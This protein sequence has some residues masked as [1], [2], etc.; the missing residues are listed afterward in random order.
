MALQ[1][2]FKA[3]ADKSITVT[4]AEANGA[5]AATYQAK[6]GGQPKSCDV[7]HQLE[8]ADA[9]DDVHGHGGKT[10]NITSNP[11]GQCYWL[12]WRSW[13]AVYGQLQGAC[14][15]FVTANLTGCGFIVSGPPASPHVVHMNCSTE[16]VSVPPS[17]NMK[18][19][20]FDKEG[21]QDQFYGQVAEQLVG[22]N[23]IL[24]MA[25]Y[26]SATEHSDW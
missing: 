5:T 3:G 21:A 7:V 16:S 4:G 1:D 23:V 18:E 8:R 10:I 25:N 11:A 12:P 26:N 6:L 2:V 14:D 19:Y 17:G 9:T 13:K 24:S 22:N 20:N 15:Y